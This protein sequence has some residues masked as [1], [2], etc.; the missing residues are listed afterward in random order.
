MN[1]PLSNLATTVPPLSPPYMKIKSPTAAAACRH[2]LVNSDSASPPGASALNLPV[3]GLV[4]T[5]FLS[6]Q[7]PAAVSRTAQRKFLRDSA[8]MKK[9]IQEFITKVCGVIDYNKLSSGQF[10]HDY[11]KKTISKAHPLQPPTQITVSKFNFQT[12]MIISRIWGSSIS[13]ATLEAS[14]TIRPPPRAP[15]E[16][17]SLALTNTFQDDDKTSIKLVNLTRATRT[18][19]FFRCYLKK[20][21]KNLCTWNPPEVNTYSSMLISRRWRDTRGQ[22]PLPTTVTVLSKSICIR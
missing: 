2:R 13:P 5:D 20:E 9:Y 16:T 19:L 12:I 22:C 21:Q 3:R 10:L 4:T 1:F 8:K 14:S 11:K 6:H 15:P 17:C 18:Y 7:T